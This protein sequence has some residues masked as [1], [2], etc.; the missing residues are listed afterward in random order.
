MTGTLRSF[1]VADDV[2]LPALERARSEGTTLTAILTAALDS[3]SGGA[4][5]VSPAPLRKAP[6]QSAALEQRPASARPEPC[7]HPPGRR[8]KG[9][10]MACGT[11]P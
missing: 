5:A 1:R 8:L 11:R 9:L 10:C 4:A 3:Y 6:V 7:P 2:W